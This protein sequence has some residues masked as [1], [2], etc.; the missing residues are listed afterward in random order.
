MSEYL[1]KTRRAVFMTLRNSGVL[2]MEAKFV[3]IAA[4]W[5]FLSK[6]NPR[7]YTYSEYTIAEKYTTYDSLQAMLK[8][9]DCAE[10]RI[11]I[12]GDPYTAE[13]EYVK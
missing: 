13:V 1:S 8:R 11:K 9:N 12:N 10:I 4:A 6:F 7:H 2:E 3:S 5:R